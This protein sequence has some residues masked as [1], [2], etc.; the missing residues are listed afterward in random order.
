M[1]YFTGSK[2]STVA[3]LVYLLFFKMGV[4][5]VALAR[6]QCIDTDAFQRTV[7]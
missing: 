7:P 2:I 3:L 1:R 4:S 5:Q 6:T